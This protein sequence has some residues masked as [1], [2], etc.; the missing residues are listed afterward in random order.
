MRESGASYA[1]IGRVL[2][3]SA[4]RARQLV[5][6]ARK[7]RSTATPPLD[8]R[9]RNCLKRHGIPFNSREELRPYFVALRDRKALGPKA[10]RQIERWLNQES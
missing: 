8:A 5:E 2:G 1:D 4:E 10:L 9:T 7:K 3:V 6:K